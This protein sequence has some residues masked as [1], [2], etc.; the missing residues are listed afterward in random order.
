[1][2]SERYGD[3]MLKYLQKQNKGSK[4]SKGG[5]ARCQF[6]APPNRFGIAAGFRWDGV[7]RTNDFEARLLRKGKEGEAS[8]E[9][10]YKWSVE[11][12]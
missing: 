3:P 6:T 2:R 11:D 1:M 12:M 4:G 9:A 8:A 5:R 10:A 7:S